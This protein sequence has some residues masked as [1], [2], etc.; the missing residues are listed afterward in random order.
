M[1]IPKRKFKPSRPEKH[2][3]ILQLPR[4]LT[5]SYSG[6]RKQSYPIQERRGYCQSGSDRLE[7]QPTD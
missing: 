2:T 3:S 6:A 1:I 4:L 5:F 7:N